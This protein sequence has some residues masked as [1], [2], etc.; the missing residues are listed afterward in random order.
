MAVDDVADRRGAHARA[1]D[2][3]AVAGA[4]DVRRVRRARLLLARGA[5]VDVIQLDVT[6]ADAAAAVASAMG[7]AFDAEIVATL[8]ATI[9]VPKLKNETILASKRQKC[10]NFGAEPEK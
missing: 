3:S 4:L 7:R 5:A 8:I 6:D 10:D 9:L 1:V 2:A